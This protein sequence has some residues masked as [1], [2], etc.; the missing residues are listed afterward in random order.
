LELFS[1]GKKLLSILEKELIETHVDVILS[2]NNFDFLFVDL[3][4]I[5]SVKLTYNLL[6]RITNGIFRLC[7]CFNLFIKNR[8][9]LMVH[10]TSTDPEKEKT[11]IQDLID[12]KDQMD[13]LVRQCFS[14]NDRF[15]NS[16]KEAFETFINI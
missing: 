14:N 8:G 15:G 13:N 2:G 6:S 11:L 7:T 3:K 16:L 1:T 4:H 5:N 9:K 12:F 10:L